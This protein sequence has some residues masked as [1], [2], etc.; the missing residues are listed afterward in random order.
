MNSFQHF[1][2]TRMNVDWKISRPKNRQERNSLDF[3]NYRFDIFEKTC[4]PSVKSQ[5]NKNFI[6]IILLDAELPD[7]FRNRLA[8]L[9]SEMDFLPVYIDSKES[10]LAT[11]KSSIA[12]NVSDSISHII[13]T[14]FDSDDVMNKNFI[15]I[16]QH[17]FLGQDFEFINFPFGYLYQMKQQKL[18]LRQWL[19]APCHTLIEKYEDLS[20]ETVSSY[21]HAQVLN[22]KNRQ[23][24]IKPMWLMTAHEKNVRTQFDVN[25]AW[26]PYSR[27]GSDFDAKFNFPNENILRTLQE[28][29][30]QIK[31]IIFSTKKWDSLKIKLRKITTILCPSLVYFMKKIEYR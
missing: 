11:L 14:N 25:A 12:E 31:T 27:L 17:Q 4:Y 16:I 1:L 7:S 2:V 5:T 30:S 13:T 8:Y 3:L 24:I 22:H 26:Q 19:T 29:C 6:W 15:Q 9:R 23:V 28:G 10:L 18:F 20:F 21:S